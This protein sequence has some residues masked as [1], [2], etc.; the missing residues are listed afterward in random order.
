[1]TAVKRLALNL[2]SKTNQKLAGEVDNTAEP[3]EE[4]ETR[5]RLKTI[6]ENEEDNIRVSNK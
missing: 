1:M 6:H 2:N 4:E 5:Q 3:K